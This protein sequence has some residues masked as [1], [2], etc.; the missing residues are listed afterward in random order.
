[1][2]IKPEAGF[3]PADIPRKEFLKPAVLAVIVKTDEA[4]LLG[5]R[6]IT[7]EPR[8]VFQTVNTTFSYRPVRLS[9]SVKF[10]NEV[11]FGN[12]RAKLRVG[13]S[14][15]FAKLTGIE[16]RVKNVGRLKNLSQVIVAARGHYQRRNE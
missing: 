2:F 8:H 12:R 15:N 4:H 16:S 10:G 1:V 5:I 7:L 3:R 14:V 13:V 11:G 9:Q 6:K